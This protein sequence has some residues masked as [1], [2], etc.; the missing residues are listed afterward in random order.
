MNGGRD[1][2]FDNLVAAHPACNSAVR[3]RTIS[4][5]GG[6]ATT[7]AAGP[8]P[9]LLPDANAICWAVAALEERFSRRTLA[10][11]LRGN[12]HRF[13]N[14]HLRQIAERR[15]ARPRQGNVT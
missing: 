8:D 5:P 9:R 3:G 12:G 13:P 15:R 6:L 4:P 11:E 7:S 10:R 14:D 1:N 2:S